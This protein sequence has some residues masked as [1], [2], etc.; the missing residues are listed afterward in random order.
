MF[1]VSRISRTALA[2]VLGLA[3]LVGLNVFAGRQDWRWDATS[4]KRHSLTAATTAALQDLNATVHAVAFYRPT[5]NKAAVEGLFERFASVTPQF[6]YEF[7]DPDRAPFR[8]RELGVTQPNTVVLAAGERRE[9]VLFPEEARLANAVIRVSTERTAQAMAVTGHGELDVNDPGE[10]GAS[11]LKRLL[12]DQGAQVGVVTLAQ[13]DA[14]PQEVELLLILGPRQDFFPHELAVLDDFLR[15]GGRLFTAVMAEEQ[16]NLD[17]WL[18]ARLHV[19]RPP[20]L[21][22]DSLSQMV[23]GDALSP[24]SQR[25]GDSPITENFNVMTLFPTA[26]AFFRAAPAQQDGEPSPL[27]MLV[28]SGEQAWLEADIAALRQGQAELD[29]GEDDAGPL[30]LAAQYRGAPRFDH[31]T[32]ATASSPSASMDHDANATAETPPPADEVRV[33]LFGDQDFLSNGFIVVAGNKDLVRNSLNWLLE[34][35]GL[36]SVET[37]KAVATFLVMDDLERLFIT[38]FPPVALPGACVVLAV[39]TAM[40]RRR[41]RAGSRR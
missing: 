25:Y 16:T 18:T 19:A 7:V 30:W 32:N 1:N 36:I 37:P 3:I 8:A 9:T 10:T 23:S 5:D 33:V 40:R 22:V 41:P 39:L 17:E 35:E 38:L 4:N 20:G 21:V 11:E 12:S 31:P 15:R 28:E 13:I 2:G 14:V 6:S 26:S 27:R 29:P 34:R 24:L